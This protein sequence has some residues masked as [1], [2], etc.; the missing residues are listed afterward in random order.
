MKHERIYLNDFDKRSFIDTYVANSGEKH[1][2]MLVIPGG[3]YYNVCTDREGEPI[4]LKFFSLGY[5]CFVLNYR[6]GTKEDVYPIQITDAGSAMIY[7]KEHAEEFSI[8]PDRV[9][10]VGFSAGGHLAGSLATMFDYPEVIEAFGEKSRMIRPAGA[11]LSY[12]VTIARQNTHSNTF[13]N[14]L[15]KP[16]SEYT[17]E[18]VKKFSIDTAITEN[19]PPIFLWHTV[20]DTVV[21]IEGTLKTALALTAKKIPYKLSVYPYGPHG[22]ALSNGITANGN[23]AYIQP[24]AEGWCEEADAFFKTL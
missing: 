10:V 3:G 11:I 22:L 12:P 6:C 4:A 5:N 20:E 2:A 7:I 8:D 16:L 13:A 14:L 23:Q 19:T 15:G 21:P 17:D 9:F 18:D 24:L 1:P